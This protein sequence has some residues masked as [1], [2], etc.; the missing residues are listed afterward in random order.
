MEEN[1]L[2]LDINELVV[3][4]IKTIMDDKNKQIAN[5]ELRLE[6]A[7]SKIKEL[8]D[9]RDQNDKIVTLETAKLAEEVGYDREVIHKMPLS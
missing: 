4:R 5:L 9:K 8:R 6:N 2:T 1:Y 3:D 7:N